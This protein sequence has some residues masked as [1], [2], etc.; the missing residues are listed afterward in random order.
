MLEA[1][2]ESVRPY[3]EAGASPHVIGGLPSR[4]GSWPV[5]PQMWMEAPVKVQR[6]SLGLDVHGCSTNSGRATKVNGIEQQT[7][8][9]SSGLVTMA[10]DNTNT[11]PDFPTTDAANTNDPDLQ[12]TA[13]ILTS[14]ACQGRRSRVPSYQS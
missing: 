12:S 2:G 3:G 6:T 8:G 14:W 10:R 9:G 13:A 5:E 7:R 11:E 4:S 1:G